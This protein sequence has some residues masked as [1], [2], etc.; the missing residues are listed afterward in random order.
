ML[1]N[2]YFFVGPSKMIKKQLG[3]FAKRNY[4]KKELL[5]IIKGPILKNRTRGSFSVDLNH[6]IDPLKN[7]KKDFGYYTNHSCNPNAFISIIDKS[8]RKPHIEVIARRKIKKG[9]EIT[10]DYASFEYET[11]IDNS[12]CGCGQKVCRGKIFG[13]KNLP[14]KIK[15]KYKKEGIVPDYLIELDA[16]NI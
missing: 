1:K 6:H 8:Y 3:V 16:E 13:F 2:S 15:E 9:K 11:T 4:N 10:I 5:F 7:G 14:Y 12:R